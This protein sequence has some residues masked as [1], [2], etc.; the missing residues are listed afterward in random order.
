MIELL[1]QF[2]LSYL[3]LFLG[4]I[5]EG[6]FIV[7]A[8]SFLAYLGFFSLPA[9]LAV[10]IAGVVTGDIVWYYL[11]R[12]FGES[13]LIKIRIGRFHLFS[14][15]RMK[16]IESHFSNGTAGRTLFVAKF[17]Y[18]LAHLTFLLAGASKMEFKKFIK[19]AV[20]SSTVWA[21]VVVSLGYLFGSSFALIQ[22]YTK[23]IGISLSIVVI[24][25]IVIQYLVNKEAEEKI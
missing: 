15:K 2:H 25:I 9:V 7:L 1:T 24:V 11:G 6:E 8:A 20:I 23:D 10:T 17:L 3:V 21:I 13:F 19:P 16:Y 12:K 5:I 14:E 22:Q 4:I 18:G